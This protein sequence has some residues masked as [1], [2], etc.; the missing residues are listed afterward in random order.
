MIKSDI[1]W[2]ATKGMTTGA[3]LIFGR[4]FCVVCGEEYETIGAAIECCK[5]AEPV[6]IRRV[7]VNNEMDFC[8]EI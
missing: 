6:D 3:I 2:T 8:G 1:S 5:G 7:V 4:I